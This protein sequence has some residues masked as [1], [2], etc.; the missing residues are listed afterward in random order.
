MSS[1]KGKITVLPDGSAFGVLSLPLPKDHWIYGS[2]EPPPMPMRMGRGPKREA[3]AKDIRTAARYAV[4]AS[5]MRGTEMDF[6]P[7]AM[8]QNFVVGLLGYWTADGL[9]T[10]GE[11]E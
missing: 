7:D 6:D 8:V 2:S 4:R 9:E 3:A 11:G 1:N 5:T 10:N